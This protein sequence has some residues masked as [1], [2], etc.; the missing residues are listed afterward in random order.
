MSK[1]IRQKYVDLGESMIGLHEVE[2]TAA[3]DTFTVPEM[4]D[5]SNSGA[6]CAQLERSLDPSGTNTNGADATVT[7]SNA[8]NFVVTLAGSVGDKVIIATVH[9]GTG[10]TIDEA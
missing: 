9:T 3:S 1:I 5:G 10:N 4:S 8:T 7:V 2:L 6:S